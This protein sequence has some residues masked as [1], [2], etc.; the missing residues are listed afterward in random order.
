MGIRAEDLHTGVTVFD[1]RDRGIGVIS[2]IAGDCFCV[3]TLEDR[4]LWFRCDDIFTIEPKCVTMQF[5]AEAAEANA[6]PA[7][8]GG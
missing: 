5:A 1:I 7:G 4:T 2:A 3:T 6:V 8:E